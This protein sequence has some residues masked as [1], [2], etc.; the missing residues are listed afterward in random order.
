MFVRRNLRW[1]SAAV[2]IIWSSSSSSHLKSLASH[3]RDFSDSGGDELVAQ[4]KRWSLN[5]GLSAATWRNSPNRA[6]PANTSGTMAPAPLLIGPLWWKNSKVWL[7]NK[8]ML[9]YI[10]KVWTS[11]IGDLP[12]CSRSPTNRPVSVSPDCIRIVGYCKALNLSPC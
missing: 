10:C 6:T 3:F 9:L 1:S 12:P 5:C 4:R 7:C 11:G 2:R 8:T